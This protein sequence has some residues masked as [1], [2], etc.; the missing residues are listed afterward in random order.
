[1]VKR[2]LLKISGKKHLPLFRYGDWYIEF[3]IEKLNE[4]KNGI[5]KNIFDFDKMVEILTENKQIQKSESSLLPFTKAVN[6]ILINNI[7]E[8]E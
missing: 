3:L 5:M 7:Y 6:M 4:G 1:V 2:I 8:Q